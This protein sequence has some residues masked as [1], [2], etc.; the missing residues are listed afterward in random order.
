MMVRVKRPSA[1][2]LGL[3]LALFVVLVPVAVQAQN[4]NA[5][6][7][8]S[9]ELYARGDYT[10]AM[11][12]ARKLETRIKRRFGTKHA[13]YAIALNAIARVYAAQGHYAQAIPLYERALRIR[14]TALGPQ[15]S[16]VAATLYGLAIA[17][18][19]QGHYERAALTFQRALAIYQMKYGGAHVK[20]AGVLNG[21]ANVFWVQGQYTKAIRLYERAIEIFE[22]SY[23]RDHPFVAHPLANLANVYRRIGRYEDAILLYKRALIIREKA[24]GREHPDLAATLNNLAAILASQGNYAEALPLYE[25]ALA[26]REKVLGPAHPNLL[27]TLIGL[28]AIYKNS[29]RLKDSEDLLKRAITIGELSLGKEHL[30]LASALRNLASLYVGLAR[31]EDAYSLYQRATSISEKAL[32][33]EHPAVAT[34]LNNLAKLY[35]ATGGSVEALNFSRRAGA[36]L[37]SRMDRMATVTATADAE[38]DRIGVFPTLV[39]AAFSVARQQ[40]GQRSMLADEAL[41]AAQRGSQTSAGAAL[42]QMAARFGARDAALARIVR[43]Q[44]DLIGQWKTLD[45]ALIAALAKPPQRR[46]AAAEEGLRRQRSEA[47]RKIAAIAARLEKEFPE[48]AALA[49]PKPL[50][51]AEV[52]TLL[53]ADEALVAYLVIKNES[54]VWAVTREGLAWERIGAGG[55]QLAPQITALRK[56]LDL[57]RLASGKP[58]LFDL[59]LAHKLYRTLFGPVEALIHGKRQLLLVPSG[60]L[61]ALPFH[62]LLT[63]PPSGAA[64]DAKT[65]GRYRDQPWLLKRHAV[66]ILPS[67]ASLKAL[68]L[69]ARK[70]RGAKPLIGFGDPVFGPEG[71]SGQRAATKLAANTRAY[72]EFWRGAGVD[73]DK[74]AQALPRLEDT[75]KELRGVAQTL[76]VPKG[77]IYLR[78]GASETT[79]KR[80]P[81]NDYRIVYFATHGL[82]AG[83]VK[84]LGEPSLALTLP[85]QP[86]E[87][88]DGLLTASEVAQ[89]KLNA[90][91]VVLSA[92]NTAAGDK[93]GAEALSGLARAFFYA[94]ARALLVSHWAVD[95]AAATRLTTTTFD[96]LKRNP[97]LGRAEALRLA[98]LDYLNDSSDPGN[99]YPAFWGPFALVGEGAVQ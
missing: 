26:I 27:S 28:G 1:L 43:E 16:D 90:D 79:V 93:P 89:L 99:A 47:E 72:S 2:V 81:L 86:S 45:K 95:S 18:R 53:G 69:F 78:E 38:T 25:R 63:G 37:A 20:V 24:L 67:L 62:L 41:A 4:L 44:Q 54:Y 46:N 97:K 19:A 80:K 29:N 17:Y 8:G 96:K 71:G 21:L 34:S 92:C 77:D 42:A 13:N 58:E 35:G 39:W 10:G 32:G 15:H 22:K 61:T 73:R 74:L 82:I 57:E 50:S 75:A 66:T 7:K 52:Q 51:V 68:R 30:S 23:G 76:G 31:Y 60:P 85:K 64:P 5:I 49:N 33:R 9:N 56:S 98:M 6:L 36:I 91:W 12:A 83:D 55:E 84:G 40:Q 48:Y 94:G 65:L 14:E 87:T 59:A 88:D 11:V 70:D 3:A